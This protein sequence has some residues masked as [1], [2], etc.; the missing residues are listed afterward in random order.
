MENG[1]LLSREQIFAAD[2]TPS[3]ELRVKEWGGTVRIKAMNADEGVEF[4]ELLALPE[5]KDRFRDALVIMTVVDA[6]GERIFAPEDL[7][8]LR[9]RGARPFTAVYNL[10]AKLN[11]FGK[12]AIE[13]AEKN[14]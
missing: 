14:S 1:G 12:A 9:A 4:A 7:P 8:R 13:N 5:F 10:A 2:D 11:G 3:E 6:G